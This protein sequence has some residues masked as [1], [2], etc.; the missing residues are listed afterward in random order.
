MAVS[1]LMTPAAPSRWPTIDLGDE[2]ATRRAWSPK[3]VLD[4]ARLGHV[5]EGRRGAVG[6]DVVDL[7][8]RDTGVAQGHGHGPRRATAGRLGRRDVERIRGQRRA[9]HL[10]MD[11]G[12]ARERVLRRL[13]DHH[14]GALAEQEPVAVPVERPRRVLGIVVALGQRAHVG[15]RRERDGQQGR[16]RAT[17]EDHVHLAPLDHPQAVQER[18]DGA[19]AG[20]HLGDDRPREA[21]LHRQQAGGHRARQG[22][23]G[24]RADLPRAL[25]VERGRAVDDLLL[26]ATAGVDGNGDPVALVKVVCLEVETR[27]PRP[28]PCRRPCRGG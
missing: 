23:D 27:S 6:H 10:G 2:I 9:Q 15:Q 17:R 22:R 11:G 3:A 5:V 20:G 13:E 28:L 25:G 7:V 24:E 21:V 18:D 26:A 1:A 8:G 19:G 16:L 12:A 14:A 4:G